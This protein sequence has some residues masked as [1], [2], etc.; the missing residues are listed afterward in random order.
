MKP[1]SIP[2]G[3]FNSMKGGSRRSVE[4]SVGS[5]GTAE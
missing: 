4:M 5:R 1:G 3:V 2:N